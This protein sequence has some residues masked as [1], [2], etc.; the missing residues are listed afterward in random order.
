MSFWANRNV[1]VTGCTGFLGRVLT[2]E[3][4]RRRASVVG[5]VRD[6]VPRAPFFLDGVDRQ[7]TIVA[8][9]VEDYFLLERTLADYE[10]DVAFHLA[11]Q[12]IVPIANRNPRA[13]FETN[14][15]GTWNLLEACRLVSG[16]SRVVVASSDKAYGAHSVL[17]YSEDHALQGS[18][19]Y[20]VSKSCAD[21][22]ATAYHRTYGTPVSVTRCGNLFGPGDLNFSRIVPGTIRSAFEGQRPVIRSD[23]SPV[24]DYIHV[25]DVVAGY[26]LLAERMEEE[27]AR[28]RAFN[29]GTGEPLSVLDLTRRILALS[30]REDL[31]PVIL[32]EARAEIQAQFLSNELARTRLAW[33]PGRSIGERLGETIAWYRE[34]FARVGSAVV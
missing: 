32:D 18:H 4:I 2:V 34:Y 22:I 12:A 11:A 25:D 5:L 13:T 10:I 24:R 8:G 29:F 19:P 27:D 21:L 3:L 15:R 6:V 26:L 23:G 1:L 9:G 20:D 31:E 16:V 7:I 17:P 30:H 14:I 33:R 28:G